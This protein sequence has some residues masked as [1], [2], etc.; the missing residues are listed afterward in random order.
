MILSKFWCTNTKKNE[1]LKSKIYKNNMNNLR[2]RCI[3]RIEKSD[4]RQLSGQW[5][6]PTP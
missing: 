3:M 5:L 4:H 2:H 1:L 6:T